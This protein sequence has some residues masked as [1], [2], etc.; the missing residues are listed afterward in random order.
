MRYP[1]P[2]LWR[3]RPLSVHDG[4]TI[5]AQV[6]R[7]DDDQSVWAV[8]LKDVFAPELS[9]AGGQECRSFVAQWLAAQTDGTDW[10]FVLETFRTPRSDVTVTSLSRLVG[11]VTSASGAV[12]NHDVQAF[13][14]TSGYSG[15]IGS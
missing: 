3:V 11:V 14:T 15:G 7:G 6:D 8:R 12:L 4:D 5:L 2:A 1:T 13:I 9:Q 10:P